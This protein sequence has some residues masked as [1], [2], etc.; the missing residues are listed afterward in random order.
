MGFRFLLPLALAALLSAC[1]DGQGASETRSGPACPSN[2]Q[3]VAVQV[4][5]RS[6]ID[7][8]CHGSADRAGG[9]DLE[10]ADLEVQLFGH[11]ALLCG[12][13]VRVVPGDAASSHLIAKLRGTSDCGAPMPPIGDPLDPATVD[14]MAS[15]IDALD[16][17]TTC[18]SWCGALCVDL[19]S[20]PEHCGECG[21][22]CPDTAACVDGAC[23]CPGG[24]FVCDA[25]C[26]DRTSD[27]TNCGECGT[28]CGELFCLQG[29]CS[30]DCGELT[31]CSGACVDLSTNPNHCG[32]CGRTCGPGTSCV[33][34]GCQ[35]G[36]A[37]IS[38][39]T[40]VQSIFSASCASNGCH[41]G[42]GGPGSPGGGP[43]GGGASLDL[44]VG[45]AHQS[46]LSTTTPCGP[47]VAPGD[48]AASILIG[49]LTGSELCMGSL[50]PKGDP[51]LAPELIDTI[52]TW[53]CQG[54]ENN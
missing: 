33:D 34:G 51:A 11:E 54:A 12:G 29:E 26:V 18:E 5:Q 8:D 44:T 36:A 42:A 27:P 13:E 10:T 52:A 45:N 48:A 49:K 38:F 32:T 19:M 2:L 24:A 7:A 47:V 40:D 22:A 20:S 6:C 17:V 53:I 46:L 16:P 15:W 30:A 25:S 31:E 43:G 21:N 28:D 39:A 3:D 1:S 9:L 23:T 37:T 41:N 35:C 4:F 50:M 14:C